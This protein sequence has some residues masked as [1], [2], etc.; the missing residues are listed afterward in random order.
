MM[1][2]QHARRPAEQKTKKGKGLSNPSTYIIIRTFAV[3]VFRS[4][5]PR[6]NIIFKITWTPIMSSRLP[7]LANRPGKNLCWADHPFYFQYIKT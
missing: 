5:V 1:V 6:N 7:S 4:P 3:L 2:S